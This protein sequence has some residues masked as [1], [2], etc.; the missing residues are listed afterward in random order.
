MH[1]NYASEL[2]ATFIP[3][4]QLTKVSD[5]QTHDQGVINYSRSCKKNR[6]HV[7]DICVRDTGVVEARCINEGYEVSINLEGS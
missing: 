3:N 5:I 6:N 2:L 1:V 7:Q 4:F